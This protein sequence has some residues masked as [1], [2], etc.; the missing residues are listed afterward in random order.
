METLFSDLK[1]IALEQERITDVPSRDKWM[2][3]SYKTKLGAGVMLAASEDSRPENITLRPALSGWHRVYVGIINLR[4]NDY[5]Y[6]KLTGQPAF[7][8]IR[9][10]RRGSP[11][12]WAPEEYA[13]EVYF[14]S[15]DLTSRDFILAKP[16]SNLTN[17]S[18]LLW[19]RCVGMS[20][21]EICTHL[22]TESNKVKCIQMH[23]D[24]DYRGEETLECD[25]D[26]LIK[27]CAVA[28]TN[29]EFATIET[30]FD[31]DGYDYSGTT[32]LH[33]HARWAEGDEK[34]I[35]NRERL[36]QKFISFARANGLKLFAGVRMSVAS[37]T[38][39]YTMPTWKLRFVDENPQFHCVNRDGSRV[40]ACSY[41]YKETQ[42][43]MLGLL[44]KQVSYGFDGVTMIF[45]RGILV[46][47]EQ[48]VIDRFKKLHPAIDPYRLPLADKRLSS[49]R[50]GIMTEFMRRVRAELGTETKIN[51]I[52][53]FNL[54]TPRN[55]GI[56]IEEWAAEGLI[57][58]VAQSE[59]N[60]YE[61]LDGLMSETE[62]QYIDMD[63]YCARIL[64]TSVIK[65]SLAGSIEKAT[66][67]MD[68]FL[69]LEQKYGVK[70]YHVL[71]WSNSL[72]EEKYLE[73]VNAL[74]ARGAKR[75]L[76]WN[77][78]A[79]MWNLPEWYNLTHVGNRREEGITK[80]RFIR[81]IE[82]EG[83]DISQFNNNWRG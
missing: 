37:F 7:T 58:M 69:R 43:Y 39:P 72:S 23:I 53:D 15:F 74:T 22:E 82:I 64:E 78:Y 29:A 65:R 30:S 49:V 20:D 71:P 57:D 73:Y 21:E 42:D 8:G 81:M 11:I 32:F 35:K 45:H 48:P 61:D 18:C 5:T 1:R 19:I 63:K 31:W 77:A 56:D 12:D 44:K 83:A 26:Y 52:T 33:S 67:N 4:S 60:V 6:L 17:A 13:E 2:S 55:I 59:I 41:A 9:H 80:R 24:A 54:E 79:A 16:D 68:G 62:P 40:N 25:D 70:V 27:L 34:F 51:I 66:G 36:Y 28:D 47:F 76:A 75:F 10:A 3:V 38:I 46:G 14:G 50:C